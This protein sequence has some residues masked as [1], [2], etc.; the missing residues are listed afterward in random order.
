M[1]F[2]LACG[3]RPGIIL[4]L[5]IGFSLRD[6]CLDYGVQACV[7]QDWASGF[8]PVLDLFVF[9]PP[10]AADK[11]EPLLALPTTYSTSKRDI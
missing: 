9:D 11:A 2:R 5:P 4:H 3:S 8:C 10:P 1:V 7:G 6:V